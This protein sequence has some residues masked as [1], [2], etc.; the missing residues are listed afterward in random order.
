MPV[1]CHRSKSRDRVLLNEIV[2][3]GALVIGTTDVAAAKAGIPGTGPRACNHSWRKVLRVGAHIQR[4]SCAA[5]DF[6]GS[7][8]IPQLFQKPRLL[9]GTE[10]GLRGIR[11]ADV[12]NLLVPE[13]DGVGRI[14]SVVVSAAI[15]YLKDLFRHELGI[16]FIKEG[17]GIH[18]ASRVLGSVASLVGDNEFYVPAPAQRP[19]SFQTIDCR[20]IVGLLP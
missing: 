6:P 4:R 5:P 8:R 1:A 2:D 18:S 9:L 17:C 11:L 10:Q 3:F 12:G 7:F 14:A 13:T 19:V 15:E 16:V 20:K